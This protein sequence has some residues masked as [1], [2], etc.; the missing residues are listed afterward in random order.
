MKGV[1]LLFSCKVCQM[2]V[3]LEYRNSND[4]LPIYWSEYICLCPC[5]NRLPVKRSAGLCLTCWQR[6]DYWDLRTNDGCHRQRL[7]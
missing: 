4:F 2:L 5:S 1:V 6:I 3:R 7:W